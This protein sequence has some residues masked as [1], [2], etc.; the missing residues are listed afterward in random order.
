MKK[1]NLETENV[2]STIDDYEKIYD[3]YRKIRYKSKIP[4]NRI[5]VM[6]VGFLLGVIY[7]YKFKPENLDIYNS[8]SFEYDY[9]EIFQHILAVRL[10]QFIFCII[11]SFNYIGIVLAYGL[12]GWIGFEFGLILFFLVYNYKFMGII[13]GISMTLPH[14]IFYLMLFL[15]IFE[16]SWYGKTYKN[17]TGDTKKK[18]LWKATIAV[19]LL[20]V[21][22]L[23]EIFVNTL[24]MQKLTQ[25][26]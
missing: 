17:E 6:A 21:A 25:M 2:E 12:A 9:S 8:V 7:F 19:I 26:I 10:K 20:L 5:I 24:C 4:D 22:I 18:V 16:G 13:L 14:G 15:L 23:C 1:F 11:C 3:N